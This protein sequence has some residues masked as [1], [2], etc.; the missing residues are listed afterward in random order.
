MW[1]CVGAPV[2]EVANPKVPI[3]SK[4]RFS[5]QTVVGVAIGDGVIVAVVWPRSN[6]FPQLTTTIWPSGAVSV[7]RHGVMN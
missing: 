7:V 5:I 2:V 3:T 6:P 4:Q 1:V